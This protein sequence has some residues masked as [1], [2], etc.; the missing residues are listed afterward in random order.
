MTTVDVVVTDEA[1]EYATARG[2][3]VYVRSHPHRCCAGPLTLLDT[4]TDRPDDASAF[5]TVPAGDLSVRYLGAPEAGPHV[6]TIELRGK[7]RQ[8][9]I[10]YW[11]GCAYKV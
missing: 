10:S 6:L 1:R 7:H 11:D 8:R 4:T 5:T 3:V 2:G 9:L